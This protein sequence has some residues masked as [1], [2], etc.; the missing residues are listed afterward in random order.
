MET[1]FVAPAVPVEPRPVLPPAPLL[2]PLLLSPASFLWLWVLPIAVLLALNFQGYW[3]VE[4]N[5]TDTQREMAIHL[6]WC[7]VGNLLAGLA[8]YV[9]ARLRP[10]LSVTHPA[11]GIPALVVQVATL[12]VAVWYVDDLLPRSVTAWIYPS[13]RYLF[14]QFAFGMLPLFLGILRIA[15]ARVKGGTGRAIALNVAL[16]AG[17]PFALY[18]LFN[19]ITA[20]DSRA[21]GSAWIGFVLVSGFIL[22]G[23]LMFI[24][25]TR[26]LVIGFRALPLGSPAVRL[27]LVAGVALVLPLAGLWLNRS[28]DFPVDFQAWE[29]Y[30]LTVANA[31]VLLL[32]SWY[33]ETRP[34][35][36]WHLLCA[37][38]PFALYFFIVFLP[39]TP[40]SILAI[41]ALGAGVLVL[42]PTILF[43]LHLHLL[44]EAW[45]Q[46][47]GRSARARLVAGG[48]ICSLLLPGFFVG[49]ALA[50][51]AALTAALDHAYAPTVPAG[52][53]TYGASLINLRRALE[54]HRAYKNGIYYP[55]LSDFYAWVVFDNLVLPDDKLAHLEKLFFGSAGSNQSIDPVR[56]RRYDDSGV[57]ERSRMPR[58][59]A[60]V[61]RTVSLERLAVRVA[62]AA[63]SAS[64]VT[65]SLTLHN[66]GPAAAE[67]QQAVPL[68]DGVFVTGFRLQVGSEMVPGRIFEKKTALWVYTMIRDSERR[69]PGLLFYNS[70]T[71]L[72]L[73]VFPVNSGKTTTVEIDFLVPGVVD[74]IDL[75]QQA[76]SV[77]GLS[78]GLENAVHQPVA[79]RDGHGEWLVSGIDAAALPAVEREPYLHVIID[80][81]ADNG[82]DGSLADV[83]ETLRRSY[84]TARFGRVTLANHDV[85]DVIRELTPLDRLGAGD[86]AQW[87]RTMPKEGS[88][89]LDL[90][91]AHAIR[92]HRDADLDRASVFGQV[93]PRPVF[94]IVS[95]QAVARELELKLTEAWANLLPGLE[96]VEWGADKSSRAHRVDPPR[97]VPLLRLGASRRPQLAGHW[98]DFAA[99]G[100]AERL[101]YWSPARG[102]W[103]PVSG[104]QAV[105]VGAPWGQAASLQLL[106]QAHSRNPGGSGIDL[107]DLV[108]ASRESGVLLPTSSYI[109]VE[110]AAQWKMLELSE[111]QKLGQNVALEFRETPA[112]PAVWVGLAFGLW[113]VW[114]RR[115]QR[116]RSANFQTCPARRAMPS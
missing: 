11:W 97:S 104:V 112:P 92:L 79:L 21:P 95:R 60:P 30:A 31:A 10:E 2:P 91:L 87:R 75:A 27:A 66:P 70:P 23:L 100:P 3:V 83:M 39:Y 103:E 17:A 46:V 28:I 8:C 102:E 47:S 81:S 111:R 16:A 71:E 52:D 37:T 67:F 53:I 89:A 1:T 109:V 57:R 51:R 54:S 48:L 9:F 113:L 12:S 55:L 42:A 78:A 99:A 101:H 96:I 34:R 90:T 107:A 110:N 14:N 86:A 49:R 114:R 40:L 69:D 88:L 13:Q 4:G 105:D 25:L 77:E 85:T 98:M 58:T 115:G 41:L 50:D 19:T 26:A 29:T 7:G 35:L 43:V 64:V 5:M 44:H 33:R 80:R 68:P 93:P 73:K 36:N 59:R 6:G 32:A 63:G 20:V 61:P 116:Y 82:F 38:F 94:V 72:E 15:C 62:P 84:P 45:R 24:G 76:G 65:A 106:Q 22:G 108:R 56:N 74:E 18:L